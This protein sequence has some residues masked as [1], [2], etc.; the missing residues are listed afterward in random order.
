MI[1]KKYW[2]LFSMFGALAITI[3]WPVVCLSTLIFA[4]SSPGFGFTDYLSY[5]ILLPIICLY[6]L[7][8]LLFIY[9]NRNELIKTTT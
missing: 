1:K 9:K 2:G 6:G 8:G 3:Y 5:S 7:W 4:K